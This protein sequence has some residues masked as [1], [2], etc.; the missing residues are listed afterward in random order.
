[1]TT[2]TH[3]HTAEVEIPDEPA[4]APRGSRFAL[5]VSSADQLDVVQLVNDAPVVLGRTFPAQVH[6]QDER[7]SRQHAR[8]V[9]RN[10][11]VTVEDLSSRSGTYVNGKRIKDAPLF[12]GDQVT[13][14]NATVT[15]L[16]SRDAPPTAAA[17]RVIVQNPKMLEAYELAR[18]AARTE[19]SVLVL[20]ETGTGKDHLAATVHAASE[21]SHQPFRPVNCAAIP[22]KLAESILFGHE[23]RSPGERAG[24]FDD[25]SGGTLFLDEIGDLTPGAQARLLRS[26]ETKTISR[27]GG[28]RE[29]AIDV[30]VV[31]ATHCDLEKM[32]NDGAFRN[33]LLYRLNTVTIEVPPLRERR[34][35]LEPLAR[36]FLERACVEWG[37]SLRGLSSD[38]M[39]ALQAYDWP[40]NIR[41]LRNVIERA[42]LTAEPP[43]IRQRDLPRVML[44]PRAALV[45]AE[46]TARGGDE[47]EGLAERMRDFERRVI[48]DALTRTGGSRPA[49]AKLLRIPIRTLYRRIQTLGLAVFDEDRAPN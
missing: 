11:S 31:S 47:D 28:T 7:A 39:D 23:G 44:Q 5:V 46:G 1:M 33:D 27:V 26:L 43:F 29:I 40:G 21:R 22:E 30:R 35:E 34:D 14:G 17:P 19:A 32:V 41:Q 49:A 15:L 48:T 20:G 16:A 25:A 2:A 12:A 4:A 36:S 13:I 9:L 42:S 45:P 18:R 10:A 6:V 38:A 37:L 24:A 8:F 3:T